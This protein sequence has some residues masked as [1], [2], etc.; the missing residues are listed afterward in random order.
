MVGFLASKRQSSP[1][2]VSNIFHKNINKTSKVPAR[3][4]RAKM[5]FSGTV[6]PLSWNHEYTDDFIH[7]NRNFAY[8]RSIEKKWFCQKSYIPCQIIHTPTKILLIL[9]LHKFSQ[10][11]P[12]AK[13]NTNGYVNNKKQ[14]V[15]IWI[16]LE[17]TNFG[18]NK[19]YTY[20]NAC[21]IE[22]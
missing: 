4:Q 8:S 12:W 22:F 7:W 20:W 2:P 6:Q 17:Y 3:F 18:I 9:R 15:P 13:S 16:I 21:E 5:N 10:M 14:R 19:A 11:H 1:V